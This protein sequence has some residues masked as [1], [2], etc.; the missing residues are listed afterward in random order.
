MKKAASFP[1]WLRISLLACAHA[2]AGK[3]ALQ[4]GAL[5]MFPAL[6]WPSSGISLAAV[7]VL[8]PEMLPGVAIGAFVVD[9]WA[10][11]TVPVALAA[12]VGNTLEAFVGAYVLRRLGL[13]GPL[14]RMRHV[15]GLIGP[16][17]LGSATLSA[18]I[19]VASL[20]F[21]GFIGRQQIGE[22]WRTWWLA[23]ALGDITV[24]AFLL[25]WAG[26]PLTSLRGRSLE[27]ALLGALPIVVSANVFFSPALAGAGAF[28]RTCLL[29]PA[30]IAAALRFE[31]RGATA[32]TLLVSAVAIAGTRRGQGP[33][34]RE[35]LAESLF[36]LQGFLGLAAV[37]ALAF[38]AV[39]SELRVALASQIAVSAEKRQMIEERQRDA[40]ESQLL[41]EAS[42]TL[43]ESLDYEATLSRVARLAVPVLADACVVDIV[44]GDRLRRI[45]GSHVDPTREPLLRELAE[46]A[47]KDMNAPH[48]AA[49]ALRT[50]QTILLTEL[51]DEIVKRY[52]SDGRHERALRA[53]D[54]GSALIVPL[55]AHG[56]AFGAIT[57]VRARASPR[58]GPREVALSEELARR[59]A[60]A[61]ENARLYQ[62]A[63][64]SIRVRDEFLASA[65]HE[66]RTPLTSLVLSAQRLASGKETSLERVRGVAKRVDE[67]AARLTR[68]VDD[69]VTAGHVHLGRLSL[70]LGDVDL[71]AVTRGATE[72]LG[73]VLNKAG[74]PVELRVHGSVHGRWD[75]QKLGH[76]V[77]NLLV[78]AMKFG[79]GKPIEIDIDEA[80]GTA[81]L[82]VTDHGIGIDAESLPHVFEKFERAPAAR[83]YGG[84]GIGLYIARALVG[85]LGG[86]IRAESVQG[87]E[88]RFTVAL[89]VL[90]PATSH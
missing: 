68:L 41:A 15:F 1:L 42:T 49:Q 62:E 20:L 29:F 87:R 50:Q 56:H 86:T 88:T 65:S 80:D 5:G 67:Q 74:C 60:V 73:G 72:A 51:T 69:M 13:R 45:A 18:T 31:L 64:D 47:P 9:L 35:T 55:I 32:T 46:S 75:G 40:A 48:A 53:L 78:N 17:S 36:Y 71:V 25:A 22:V 37:T 33:F 84:L 76:V 34:V 16:A 63:Q 27:A 19:G 59:A 30:L 26:T 90:G 66:L 70:S 89:P 21:G 81:R 38:G 23:N 11:A 52:V 12:C 24:G 85:A 6:V 83:M 54:I 3:A 77:T 10:G 82:V 2:L 43:T 4:F 79:A 8:G 57:F 7:F 14:Q 61:V 44:E 39:V 28:L 58:Y